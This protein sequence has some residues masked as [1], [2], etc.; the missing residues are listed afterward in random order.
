[1]PE[2]LRAEMF[3]MGLELAPFPVPPWRALALTSSS[4]QAMGIARSRR[5]DI[6][7]QEG[8]TGSLPLV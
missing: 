8:Q 1:V 2:R 7:T 5:Q 6:K 4:V 3:W